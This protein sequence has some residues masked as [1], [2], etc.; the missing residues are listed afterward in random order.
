MGFGTGS[1]GCGSALGWRTSRP[2]IDFVFTDRTDHRSAGSFLERTART[3]PELVKQCGHA[4]RLLIASMRFPSSGMNGLA[5]EPQLKKWIRPDREEL[6]R[7]APPTRPRWPVHARQDRSMGDTLSIGA[8]RCEWAMGPGSAELG[9]GRC[10]PT[11]SA[12]AAVPTS[13]TRVGRTNGSGQSRVL[14]GFRQLPVYRS[15]HEVEYA[16]RV[17]N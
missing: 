8:N 17:L 3:R 1:T 16:L 5:T 9:R 13:T 15:L 12:S 14:D 2:S 6:N 11:R 10:G 7:H 4:R